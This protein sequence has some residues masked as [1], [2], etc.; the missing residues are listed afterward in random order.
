[1]RL[2]NAV[3][4]LFIFCAVSSAQD[5]E[6]YAITFNGKW[7]PA[8]DPTL[9]DGYGFQDIQNM[10]KDQQGLIGV[11]GH[12]PINTS[13]WNSTNKYPKNAFQFKKETPSE[14]H[15][16]VYATNSSGTS[17]AVYKNDTAIP[18][19]GNFSGTVWHTGLSGSELGRFSMGS[20]GTV[21]Y[22]DGQESIIWP[23]DE[24]YP[25]GFKV[26]D[27]LDSFNYDFTRAVSN[28]LTDS[29]NIATIY[30]ADAEIDSN[31]ILML[32]M[33]GADGS[34][35]FTDSSPSG[36]TVTAN[37]DAQLD[38]SAY[39]FG[40]ASGLFDDTGDYLSV[41]DSSEW[42]WGTSAFTIDMQVYL[43]LVVLGVY[44]ERSILKMSS[45]ATNY[46]EISMYG[47]EIFG[48]NYY[49]RLLKVVDN[50]T[51]LNQSIKVGGA[52]AN[53][54][55]YHI[56]LTREDSNTFS[57]YLDGT[58]QG[59]KTI[60]D[61]VLD[62]T[63]DIILFN[64][65]EGHVDE[66]R[67][68]KGVSL[69]SSNFDPPTS[70]YKDTG[71]AYMYLGSQYKIYS[72]DISIASPNSLDSDMSVYYYNGTSWSSVSGLSDGT[73]S[74]VTTLYQSGTVSFDDTKDLAKK[75]NINELELY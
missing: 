24:V 28:D 47:E 71:K 29:N 75:K 65:F 67:I 22:T 16:F 74:G 10:R 59:S 54:T 26:Y 66:V 40:T 37:G 1:M 41:P 31:T 60:S 23:G 56:A 55:W 61:D 49:I 68:T 6:S 11:K 27:P 52:L 35:T 21:I 45:G 38:T 48:V 17:K 43:P 13:A 46:F 34:T 70:A 5:M 2:F 8:N 9:I 36:Q 53:D 62:Y 30:S 14:S 15:L 19:Q 73:S 69:Y 33:D 51:V 72:F 12:T 39:A 42:N 4:L 57:T 32:H 3:C 7:E 50:V 58:L 18:D 44:P 64:E 20:Q 25:L 63:D